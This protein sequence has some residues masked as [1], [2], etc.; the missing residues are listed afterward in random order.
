[1]KKISRKFLGAA[2][3]FVAGCML[4]GLL[5]GCSNNKSSNQPQSPAAPASASATSANMTDNAG[6]ANNAVAQNNTG[7]VVAMLKPYDDFGCASGNE[8]QYKLDVDNGRVKI[9]SY[10]YTPN[11]DH[12]N[13]FYLDV[14]TAK[15]NGNFITFTGITNENGQNISGQ[16]NGITFTLNGNSLTMNID[17]K[18]GGSGAGDLNKGSYNLTP[19]NTDVYDRHDHDD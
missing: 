16:F 9:E 15:I 7:D 5:A 19:I 14:T 1:M 3:L 2:V 18:D 17:R 10:Y 13:D 4:I 6:G 11:D 8:M 12:D